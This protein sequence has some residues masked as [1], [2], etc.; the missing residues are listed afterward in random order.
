MLRR[1]HVIGGS[2]SGKTTLARQLGERRRLPV[3]HLDE[4]ALDADG[5]LRPLDERRAAAERLATE[6]EWIVEGIHLGWTEPL[7]RAADAVV[8]LDTVSARDAVLRVIARFVT[9]ALK[10]AR[11]RRG[12]ARFTRVRD[13]RRHLRDLARAIGEIGRYHETAGDGA[14][15]AADGRAATERALAPHRQ[16]VIRVSRDGRAVLGGR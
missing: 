13:Y 15:A 5:R 1:I 12:I 3:F 2:G 10:E 14:E 4:I 16:K 11:R 8:W 7:L 9:D 6:R